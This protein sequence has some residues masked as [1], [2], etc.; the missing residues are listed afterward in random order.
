M[1]VYQ[2]VYIHILFIIFP[3]KMA[4]PRHEAGPSEEYRILPMGVK[5]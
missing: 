2:R 1:L 4:W 3:M 5:K